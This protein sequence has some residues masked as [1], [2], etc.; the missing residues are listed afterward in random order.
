MYIHLTHCSRFLF[1][2]T[3]LFASCQGPDQRL[4][5]DRTAQLYG[6]RSVG[7]RAPPDA[8]PVP[9]AEDLRT[10]ADLEL[11]QRFGM[12][13][14]A[15][16]RQ[17]YERWRAALERVAQVSSLPDPVLSFAQFV[18]EVQTRT[19]PQ[20][21]RYG[22]S[23]TF[24][25]FGK[26]RLRGKV[27]AGAAEELWHRVDARRLAV[28]REIAVAYHEYGYLGRSIRI[29]TDVLAL[30]RRFE[31]SVQ[32]RVQGGAGQEDLLRLQLEIGKVEDE[33]ARSREVQPAASARLATAMNWSETGL[34]P[35]PK[36][37]E[38]KIARTVPQDLFDKAVQGNPRIREILQSIKTSE[39]SLSLAKLSR[40][41][42][43]NVGVDYLETGGALNPGTPGS[44]DDPL[45]LRLTFNLPIWSRTY[46]A[47]EREAERNLAAARHELQQFHFSLRSDIELASFRL[48]DAARQVALY[49]DTLLPRSRELMNVTRASYR[50]GTTRLL[51][52]ID[53]ERS[54]L[55]F[56]LSYWRAARD[57]LQVEARLEALVGGPL[58]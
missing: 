10:K 29:T 52:L 42:D 7:R 48:G 57:Y 1:A 25:W 19:G 40:W 33:L 12:H 27:F 11:Y 2:G 49:R 20:E 51:D 15:G 32:R 9:D 38:P 21:R 8:V 50:A 23:Q 35:L 58:R 37:D 16:L 31:P 39:R 46:D 18:E 3:L 47:E 43:F 26:L 24:P 5:D 41:P 34:L 6:T 36:L 45:S 4:V 30:L 13:H 55:N 44:G 28:R 14:N 53:S 56:E 54:L 22:L 17:A